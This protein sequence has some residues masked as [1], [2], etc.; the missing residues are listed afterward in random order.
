VYAYLANI[1]SGDAF[2]NALELVM[3]GETL[4][5]ELLT[6]LKEAQEALAV[7]SGANGADQTI[8]ANSPD[9]QPRLSERE[10]YILRCIADGASNKQIARRL[11]IAEAT[12]KVHVHP[13]QNSCSESDSGSHLGDKQGIPDR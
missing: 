2:V 3:L 5:A 9:S 12:V 13:S 4:P 1:H 8:D 10:E 11:N 7:K 6:Y